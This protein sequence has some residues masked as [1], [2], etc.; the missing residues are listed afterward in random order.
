[1]QVDGAWRLFVR[2][3]LELPVIDAH[4][5]FVWGVWVELSEADYARVGELW[6][7]EKRQR[8]PVYTASLASSLTPHYPSA[9]GLAVRLQTQPVGERPTIELEPCDHPLA[10]EQRLGVTMERVRMIAESMVHVK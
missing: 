5:P 10:F 1:M 2:G 3:C 4:S 9:L 7:T 8:E 6:S